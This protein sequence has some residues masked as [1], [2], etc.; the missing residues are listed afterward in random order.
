MEKTLIKKISLIKENDLNTLS[1]RQNLIYV[2]LWINYSHFL[3]FQ[4]RKGHLQ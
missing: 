1:K 3:F 2:N 4:Y